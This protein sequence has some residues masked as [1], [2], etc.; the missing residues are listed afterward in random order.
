MNI[1]DEFLNEVENNIKIKSTRKKSINS[2]K[3]G[4][5]GELELVHILNERFPDYTF[6][7]SVMS[8]AYTGGSNSGRAEEL[9]EEQKLI[10]CGDLRVPMSFKFTIEHKFYKEASFWDLFN[11]SSNLFTWYEQSE[12]DAAKVNKEPLLIVKYN[13]KK[14]IAFVNMK[15]LIENKCS[16]K[17][18][19]IHNNK[20]CFWLEDLLS[21]Q[22][23]FFFEE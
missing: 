19:F 16:I 5:H 18:V 14:R 6:A 12:T 9:T 1:E 20:G 15:Y 13:N 8:G 22:D 3:K 4:N 23:D 21:L 7:R 2:K 17:P 11:K 10:F